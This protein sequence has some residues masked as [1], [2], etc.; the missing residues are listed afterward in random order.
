ME[1]NVPI[2]FSVTQTNLLLSSAGDSITDRMLGCRMAV[3]FS[4]SF[5]SVE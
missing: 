5:R 4:P 1:F 3:N 2:T